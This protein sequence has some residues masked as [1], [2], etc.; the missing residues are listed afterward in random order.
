MYDDVSCDRMKFLSLFWNSKKTVETVL[1]EY[2]TYYFGPEAR[3]GR[4]LL[5]LLDDSCKD[6]Q[7][8]Q[9]I[10]QTLAKLESSVAAWVKRDWRWQE[11]VDSCR[12]VSR[13]R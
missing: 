8:P 2:A 11:I 3:T 6:P 10:E 7:R 13:R 12:F 9:K 4:E 5:D 1:D